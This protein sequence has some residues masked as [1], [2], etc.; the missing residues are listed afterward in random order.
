MLEAF[1]K[2]SSRTGV[3]AIHLRSES[4]I[5]KDDLQ[6]ALFEFPRRPLCRIGQHLEIFAT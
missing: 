6:F 1:A 2:K 4:G 3:I 5:I